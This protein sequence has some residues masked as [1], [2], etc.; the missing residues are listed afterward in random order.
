M[1]TY[2]Y[3]CAECG[4]TAEEFQRMSDPKLTTCPECGCESYQRLISCG[5]GV[6]FR[7]DLDGTSGF[8]AK[9]RKQ[10]EEIQKE[11]LLIKKAKKKVRRLRKEGKIREAWDGDIVTLDDAKKGNL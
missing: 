8:D 4:Y 11:D 2:D 10:R 3:Q 5:A 7:G 1:P 9:D 6:V